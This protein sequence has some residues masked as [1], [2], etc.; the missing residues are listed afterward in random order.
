VLEILVYGVAE[1][2]APEE[3]GV[4]PVFATEVKYLLLDIA[5]TRSFKAFTLFGTIDPGLLGTV[6]VE[7]PN[8]FLA[9]FIAV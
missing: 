5:L 1:I 4:T 2:K 8:F 3:G 7:I 9:V 6:T